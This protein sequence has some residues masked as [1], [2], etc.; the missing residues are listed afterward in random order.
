VNTYDPAD[1][2][3][4]VHMARESDPYAVPVTSARSGNRLPAGYANHSCRTRLIGCIRRTT[5]GL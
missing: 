2:I 3:V 5:A 4:Y 1:G